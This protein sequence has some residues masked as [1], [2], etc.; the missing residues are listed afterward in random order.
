LALLYGL[1]QDTWLADS[2]TRVLGLPASL[3]WHLGLCAGAVALMALAV[4][5]AWPETPD[6]EQE[7][8]P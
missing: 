2:T 7:P 5:F 1:H 8:G 6:D 3:A 4:R